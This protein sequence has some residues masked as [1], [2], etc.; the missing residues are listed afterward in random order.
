MVVVGNGTAGT[1]DLRGWKIEIDDGAGTVFTP[2]ETIV[3]SEDP[4]WAAVPNGTILTFTENSTAEGG[5]DTWIHKVNRLGQAGGSGLTDGGYAWSNIH[6]LDPI[7]IDQT[8]S[9][10]GNGLATP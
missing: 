10:F 8:A 1:V 7:Y 4:Y 6:Y 2:D 5:L 9:T 3:L